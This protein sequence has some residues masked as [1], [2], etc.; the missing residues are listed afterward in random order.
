[1]ANSPIHIECSN[2][3]AFVCLQIWDQHF[4]ESDVCML[5]VVSVDAGLALAR[6]VKTEVLA[7]RQLRAMVDIV[8]D[9]NHSKVWVPRSQ[10]R[11]I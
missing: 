6:K 5:A 4:A 2:N 3:P 8:R 7:T 10:A 11:C 9:D 1:M